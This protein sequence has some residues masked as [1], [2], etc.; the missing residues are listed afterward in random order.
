MAELDG[1][2]VSPEIK[3][4]GVGGVELPTGREMCTFV[5]V[6]WANKNHRANTSERSGG[7]TIVLLIISWILNNNQVHEFAY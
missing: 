2:Y 5:Y 6:S 1:G 7:D 4:C 3:S